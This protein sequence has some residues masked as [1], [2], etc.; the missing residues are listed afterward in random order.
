MTGANHLFIRSHHKT[1]LLLINEHQMESE[2]E[3]GMCGVKL[4]SPV[5]IQA[6]VSNKLVQ[7]PVW[8]FAFHPPRKP[9]QV[10]NFL[11]VCSHLETL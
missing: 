10:F 8:A 7:V 11:Y 5:P 2:P 4:S 1:R 9:H 3:D 6:D